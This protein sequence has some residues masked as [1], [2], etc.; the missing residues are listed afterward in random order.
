MKIQLTIK[1]YRCFVE[2]ATIE[3][4][5]GFTAFVGLNNA[6]KSTLM[7]FLLEFRNLFK[8]IGN[9]GNFHKSLYT[10]DQKTSP[11]HTLDPDEVFSNLNDQG[12]EFWF[13]FS[14]NPRERHEHSLTKALFRINRNLEWHC[15]LFIGEDQVSI[16]QNNFEFDNTLLTWQQN[17][18][19]SVELG[20]LFKLAKNL[21][22]TLYIGPFRNTINIGTR[23]NYLDIQIGEAFIKQFRI[24]K[25]GNDKS[26]NASINKLTQDIQQIFGF[27]SLEISPSSDDQSLHI[28]VNGKPYK[29]HELGSGIQ[30]FILVLANATIKRPNYLFIDE[31]ELNLHPSLQLD[32][33]TTLASY[34][35]EGVFFSTHSLGLARSAAG[36]VYT[37]NKISDGNSKVT[38]LAATPRLPEFLGEMNFS[39]HKELGFEKILL[40]EGSSEVTVMQQILRK[41]GKDHKIMILSLSGRINGE[42]GAE[43]EEVL[44][45]NTEVAAII[46]SELTSEVE[47]LAMSRQS[48]IDLCKKMNIPCHVLHKRATENY[49]PDHIVKEVF[50]DK[51]RALTDYEKLDEA[52]P[53]WSKN[54]NWKLANAMS[55]EELLTN[56]F[57]DFLNKL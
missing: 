37:V 29:Q 1:N 19:K 44:R 10:R 4:K 28:T 52:E 39:S 13:D 9:N 6:G 23:D 49:F 57:G 26:S 24:L 34:T 12:I 40:V 47:A 3:I 20:I 5:P 36:T 54:L 41:M 25:T 32:F 51:Y 8:V 31:P 15:Q 21:S 50:G 33:L 2:P 22:N 7:R 30:Q 14:Y 45:I 18:R 17:P 43:L 56:D 16:Q 11:L 48:F 38:H 42:M 46:D 27:T 35:S 55:L 53:N